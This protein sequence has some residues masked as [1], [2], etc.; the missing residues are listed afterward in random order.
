MDDTITIK[1]VERV[2]VLTLQDNFI[3]LTQ[4]DNSAVVQRA[5]PVVD[6]VMKNSI[7]AEHGFS[8]LVTVTDDTASRKLL[9]DFGFSA[10]GAARNADSLGV[11]LSDV[12]QMALS[13]GHLDHV[14]GIQA[15]V[16]KIGRR[17]VPL[18]LHP[19][20]FRTPRF[21]RMSP[22][23]RIMFP[24]FT[25]EKAAAAGAAV[26]ET[27]TPYAM[28]DGTALFLS[29]IPRTTDF[30]NGAPNLCCEIDGKEQ[31][32][33]FDD[34]T[35]VVFNVRGK[36]LVVLSGCAHSGIVNT[37]AYARE[38]TG[39]DRVMVIMGGFHLAQVDTDTVLRP[40]L[41]RLQ[42]FDPEYIVPTHCT[43]RDAIRTIETIMPDRF[44]LNMSGTKLT[45]SAA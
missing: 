5:I 11:D 15:L 21:S 1:A 40:T 10:D 19:A 35:A 31:P 45:F 22:E 23:I 3:D 25:R 4:R 18:V 30:E 27:E 29:R 14:G 41:E 38:V 33:P 39:I 44:I 28:L 9:F 24:E 13:H 34:D 12:A 32:D 8:A 20:A 37:V 16:G 42:A 7:L 17:D 2:E 6:M 36:G 43:G 26:I